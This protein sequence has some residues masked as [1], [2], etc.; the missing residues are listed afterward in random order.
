MYDDEKKH[1]P[2]CGRQVDPNEKNIGNYS[3][4]DGWTPEVVAQA[5]SE[6]GL[7]VYVGPVTANH[8]LEIWLGLWRKDERELT[9]FWD[10]AE[11]LI[12][13]AK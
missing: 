8:D 6:T 11:E 13:Q 4:A 1:C 12:A 2:H 5:A 10:R 3:I 9:P 7:N